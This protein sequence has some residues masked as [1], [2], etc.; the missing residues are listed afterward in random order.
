MRSAGSDDV[1]D[2]QQGPRCWGQND[3][4]QLMTGDKLSTNA[5]VAALGISDVAGVAVGSGHVCAF[6]TAGAAFCAGENFDG[7]L[8]NGTFD[9]ALMPVPVAITAKVV[10]MSI[11]GSHSCAFDAAGLVVLEAT[12][13]T[14]SASGRR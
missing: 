8:G 12:T 6:T 14:S 1:R 4:G 10:G 5:P 7:R 11:G 2:L 13:A 3:E 9:E